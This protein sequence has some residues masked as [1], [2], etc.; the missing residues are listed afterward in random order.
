M[1]KSF[2]TLTLV[3]QTVFSIVFQK[4]FKIVLK[5]LFQRLL[6]ELWEL[7]G[8]YPTAPSMS[9]RGSTGL[10]FQVSKASLFFL[11][12]TVFGKG[13]KVIRESQEHSG[14]GKAK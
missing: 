3:F 4:F 13:H 9:F 11:R 5:T 2:Q 1:L 7:R 6:N 12:L 8:M 14:E 10:A